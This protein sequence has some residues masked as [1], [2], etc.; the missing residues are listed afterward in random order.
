MENSKKDN[1]VLSIIQMMYLEELGVDTSNASMFYVKKISPKN[2]YALLNIEP[3]GI[4]QHIPTFTLH[5]IIELLPKELEYKGDTYNLV[6]YASGGLWCV[7]YSFS[8]KFYSYKEFESKSLIEAAYE[9]LC[10]CA[11]SNINLQIKP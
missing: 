2:E 7:S 6:I 3:I 4:I 5:D 8:D 9:M 1:K 10:W 11:G